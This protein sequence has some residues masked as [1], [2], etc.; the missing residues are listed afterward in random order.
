MMLVE[1]DPVEA[2]LLA[3]N[4]VVDVLVEQART[5]LRVEMAVG[6]SEEAALF[7]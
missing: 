4:L 5:L 7:L 3:I 6:Q 2:Q 1:R